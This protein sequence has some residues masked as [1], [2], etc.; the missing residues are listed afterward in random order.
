MRP[1]VCVR[2]DTPAA[3]PAT[4]TFSC[5]LLLVS[6]GLQAILACSPQTMTK[7]S[8]PSSLQVA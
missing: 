8:D 1:L 3:S 5:R 7:V 6:Y 4:G 2:D